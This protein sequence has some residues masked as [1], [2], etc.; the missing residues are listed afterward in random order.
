MISVKIA[1]KLWDQETLQRSQTLGFKN[2]AFEVFKKLEW[3]YFSGRNAEN[4]LIDKPSTIFSQLKFLEKAG[5]KEIDIFWMKA[6]H[7]I[8]GGYKK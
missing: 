3:N 4:D 1:A 5:F 6:G 8:F 2:E 7:A